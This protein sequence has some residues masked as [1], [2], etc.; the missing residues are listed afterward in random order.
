MSRSCDSFQALIFRLPDGDLTADEKTAL[1]AHLRA[2]P[3]C[4]AA[5]DA[6]ADVFSVLRDDMTE[7]PAALAA[8]VMDRIRA[9]E[10]PGELRAA[11]SGARSSRRR[12]SGLAVAACLVLIVGGGVYAA[13]KGLGPMGASSDASQAESIVLEDAA[14]EAEEAAEAPAAM[15][16][17]EP[18]PADGAAEKPAEAEDAAEEFSLTAAADTAD[19][20]RALAGNGGPLYTWENPAQVPAGRE[21]AFEALI[22]AGG[23]RGTASE[24]LELIAAVEYRGVIYEFLTDGDGALYWQ[25]AAES[26]EPILSPGSAAALWEILGE[27]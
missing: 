3:D 16:A 10:A 27:E 25:D 21:A 23:D 19:E 18:F 7:A 5:Y 1:Q 6:F 2:C 26:V 12:W 24:G 4:K 14:A 8:G 13:L 9:A 22:A 15:A 17:P 11:R 20:D